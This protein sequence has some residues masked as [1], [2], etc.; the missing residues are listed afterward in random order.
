MCLVFCRYFLILS[1]HS[2]KMKVPSVSQFSL[3]SSILKSTPMKISVTQYPLFATWSVF[4]NFFRWHLWKLLSVPF[5]LP[6]FCFFNLSFIDLLI[7]SWDH[8]H[9]YCLLS[10]NK[11]Q[12]CMSVFWSTTL[13]MKVFLSLKRHISALLH[14]T[15]SIVWFIEHTMLQPS[16]RLSR[17]HFQHQWL[18]LS[19]KLNLDLRCVSRQ[20]FKMLSRF[21]QFSSSCALAIPSLSFLLNELTLELHHSMSNVHLSS[22][23]NV[24]EGQ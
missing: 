5:T 19:S 23:L 22:L 9:C 3:L 11:W 24:L 15:S 7:T 6:V 1:S 18:F 2:K 21:K 8:I 4:F 16:K 12:P 14:K 10:Q 17:T 20:L 13:G